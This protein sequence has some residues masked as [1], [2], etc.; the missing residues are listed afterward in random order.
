M[1]P[2]RLLVMIIALLVIGAGS[3]FSESIKL[4][5]DANTETDLAGYK[6]YSSLVDGGPYTLIQDVGNVTELELDLT[7]R[8]D[9]T[10]YY[11]A[12]AYDHRDNESGY[13][14]QASYTV[15]HTP[16][17]PPGGCTVKLTW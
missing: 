12:T 2:L 17:A 8:P 3:A 5:W 10:I 11:V 15:D 14:N 4:V 6:V 13:S 9:A 1:K 7:G 16:P